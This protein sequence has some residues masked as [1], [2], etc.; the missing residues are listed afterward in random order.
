MVRGGWPPPVDDCP[1]VS[2]MDTNAGPFRPA[3]AGDEWFCCYLVCGGADVGDRERGLRSVAFGKHLAC[4]QAPCDRFI[5]PP[6]TVIVNRPGESCRP[7]G[8]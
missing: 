5:T 1:V 8:G 2:I 4:G 7:A 6:Q 3:A